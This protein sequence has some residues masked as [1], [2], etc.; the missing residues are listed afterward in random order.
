MSEYDPSN[1]FAKILNDEIPCHKIFD[2]DNVLVF[3]DIMPQTRGHCL[4]LPRAPSRNL[5]DADPAAL[6]TVIPYVQRVAVAAKK[7]LNADGV[8]I[9]QFNESAA[10]QTVF[11]LHFH[12]MPI[13][14]GV[15]VKPHSGAQA[16]PAELAVL[17][18]MIAAAM[19]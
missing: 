4:V 10:G 3:M 17:A 14:E 11:H 19:H 8:R 12:V 1:L 15:P 16:D 2:D 13:F 9:M 6:A 7:A 18:K 5:L